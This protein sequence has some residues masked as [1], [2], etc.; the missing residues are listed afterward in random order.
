MN[1]ATLI[2]LFGTMITVLG[3]WC[4]LNTKQIFTIKDDVKKIV[5]ALELF[6][7]ENGKGAAI[8]LHSPDDH[9]GM[10]KLLDKYIANHFSLSMEDWIRLKE[11][12][13][14]VKNDSNTSVSEKMAAKD[15]IASLMAQIALSKNMA[16][17]LLEMAKQNTEGH[18]VPGNS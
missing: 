4:F 16:K 5:L 9:L 11:L 15:L 10:D 2:W 7:A 12:C 17:F 3:G 13:E 18:S 1:E 14:Q 8:I 6:I